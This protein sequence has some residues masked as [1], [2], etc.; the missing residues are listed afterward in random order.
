MAQHDYQNPS[1]SNSE[2]ETIKPRFGKEDDPTLPDFTREVPL[3]AIVKK[4]GNFV[5]I[6][7]EW[8]A[9]GGEDIFISIAKFK[10]DEN[11]KYLHKI[12]I[13]D[14]VEVASFRMLDTN[15]IIRK[16]SDALA[17][18]ILITSEK[19][20]DSVLEAIGY[21]KTMNGNTYTVS[22]APAES[23][24]LD[25]R[26]GLKVF[27]MDCLE[28]RHKRR[29]F[30]LVVEELLGIYAKGYSVVALTPKDIVVTRKKAV[31]GNS[32]N[33]M[34]QTPAKRIESFISNL[35]A[36][37]DFGLARREDIVYGAAA[38]L[39]VLGKDYTS[40]KKANSV[41]GSQMKTLASIESE[42]FN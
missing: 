36:L 22:R 21:F 5:T 41:S 3:K 30:D 1:G 31:L 26:I 23:W 28:S 6:Q 4:H 42:V 13:R 34:K 15:Y 27:S 37:F 24:A 2:T 17:K 40:W 12:K 38:S 25:P 9:L 35:K 19:L 32:A 16:T 8:N 29:L 33:I 11:L 7:Y 20:R 39:N 10:E 18:E 14:G